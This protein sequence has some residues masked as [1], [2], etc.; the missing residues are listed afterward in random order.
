MRLFPYN[1]K[2]FH[3]TERGSFTVVAK[4]LYEQFK[5][6][7]FLGDPYNPNTVVIQPEC[8]DASRK[9]NK[10][11]PYL[12]CEYSN[13]FIGVVQSLMQYMP[14]L[15]TIS[16]F[17]KNN[18]LRSI[19]YPKEKIVSIHLGSNNK[20]WYKTE[21][22]KFEK[23]TFLTVNT[24]NDRSGFEYLLPAFM[25]FSEGKDINLYIK[26]GHKNINFKKYIESLNCKKIIYDD[27]NLSEAELRSLYNK[28]HIFIYATNTTSFGMNIMDAALCGTPVIAT[29]G[30]AIKE[31]LPS[32]TQPVEIKSKIHNFENSIFEKM[33]SIGI[34]I[35]SIPRKQFFSENVYGE[36]VD[37]Q[38]IIDSMEYSLSN[39]EKMK[40]LNTK[41]IDF[42]NKNYSWN[43]TS[44]KIINFLL[45]HYE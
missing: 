9:T 36:I 24:S 39:Y 26:D 30:S 17:A 6:M 21:D 45:Q 40:E 35:Q 4:Q 15:M 11:V 2:L 28:A 25:K 27:S 14:P 32:W 22:K 18:I 38:S 33:M 41:H 16:D 20:I 19:N 7:D 1:D 12:A 3:N 13:P 43:D 37:E 42:I 44:K 29:M 34:P 5:I 8:I 10:F 23:F 31:F